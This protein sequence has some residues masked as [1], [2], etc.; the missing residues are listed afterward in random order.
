MSERMTDERW[1]EL[2]MLHC[3]FFMPWDEK[4]RDQIAAELDRARANEARLEEEVR[5]LTALAERLISES[6]DD[7]N[8]QIGLDSRIR[9]IVR[10]EIRKVR[11]PVYFSQPIPGKPIFEPFDEATWEDEP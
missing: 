11:V 9:A 5:R 3:E 6:I 1:H 10:E 7:H 4:I 2:K 8:A